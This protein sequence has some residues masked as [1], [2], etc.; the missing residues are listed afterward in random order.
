MGRSLTPNGAIIVKDNTCHNKAFMADNN[1]SDI[2]RSLPYLLAI[3]KESGLR[4][5]KDDS[6]GGKGKEFWRMQDDFPD[7]IFPVPML[8]LEVDDSQ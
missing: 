5:V 7:E 4:I 1:D 2:T 6:S 8:A 3:I